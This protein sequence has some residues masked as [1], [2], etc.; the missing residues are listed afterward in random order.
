M[1]NCSFFAL[2]N[3]R[4]GEE[5][6]TFVMVGSSCL[7]CWG[8]CTHLYFTVY[9]VS[10]YDGHDNGHFSPD[11]YLPG[12]EGTGPPLA[13]LVTYQYLQSNYP[14]LLVSI[15]LTLDKIKNA[16]NSSYSISLYRKE[17]CTNTF[18]LHRYILEVITFVAV[19]LVFIVYTETFYILPLSLKTLL[20][21]FTWINVKK[22][23]NN[24]FGKFYTKDSE[25]S[26]Y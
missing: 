16:L 5:L 10:R 4:E 9:S 8:E 23:F 11:R 3:F 22:V 13:P 20:T 24:S 19:I 14:C 18:T 2:T 17:Q 15:T 21:A 6:F 12:E 7:M 25:S 1:L 26:V